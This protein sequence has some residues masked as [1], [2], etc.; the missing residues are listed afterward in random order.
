MASSETVGEHREHQ[1][2]VGHRRGERPVLGHAEPRSVTEFGGYQ[3]SEP[4]LIPTRPQQAAGIRIE[5]IPSLP[6]AIGTVPAATAA[7]EPPEDPPG[8]RSCFQGLRVIPKVESVAPNTHS[9][10]TRV[11]PT[12]IAPAARSRATVWWSLGWADGSDAW[13]PTRI[14]SPATGTLS[15]IATGTPASGNRSRSVAGV[16]RVR[17]SQRLERTDELV[18]AQRTGVSRCGRGRTRPAAARSLRPSRTAA[19]HVDRRPAVVASA[20]VRTSPT[21]TLSG[22]F[23]IGRTWGTLE[24]QQREPHVQLHARRGRSKMAAPAP[25]RGRRRPVRTWRGRE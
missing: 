22:R 10:G 4:G 5:P 9:S 11:M 3:T 7:A 6:S 14:G 1:R 15:L 23:A 8:E 19:R 2:G 12:T 21:K 25:T 24:E 18:G 16:D 13:V 20:W 17:L